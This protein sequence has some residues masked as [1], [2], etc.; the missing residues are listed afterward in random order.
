[1]K[2]FPYEAPGIALGGENADIETLKEL[3]EDLRRYAE[4][5]GPSAA[6]LAAAPLIAPAA[7]IPDATAFRLV[8]DVSG[9]PRI[10]PGQAAT[11]RIYAIDR[12]GTW[13]RSYSRLWRL[14]AELPG[15]SDGGRR[16]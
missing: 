4:T 10:G 14:A 5:G 11:S 9:H 15:H 8:G 13:V 3:A 16:H 7:I 1:M 2:P 6:E 12:H